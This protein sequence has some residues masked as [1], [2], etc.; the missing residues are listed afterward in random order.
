MLFQQKK[1]LVLSDFDGTISRV[2]VGDSVLNR[3]AQKC[4]EVID[5]EVVNGSMGSREAY[6]R[7]ASLVR[8]DAGS[9][10]A[11]VLK[12]SAIDP[13]FVRFYR[14]AGKKGWMS[15]SFRT[16]LIFTFGRSWRNTVWE[17]SNFIPIPLCSATRM[18]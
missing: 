2:D 9:L 17:R 16:G 8:V 4:R 18:P 15:K 1:A 10:R 3:F 5:R 13:F 11:H 7:I 14:L 12:C 6:E